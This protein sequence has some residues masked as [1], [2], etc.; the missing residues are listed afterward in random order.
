MLS[1]DE[2]AFNRMVEKHTAALRVVDPEFQQ[3]DRVGQ[4][5]VYAVLAHHFNLRPEQVANLPLTPSFYGL[6]KACELIKQGERPAA[7]LITEAPPEGEWSLPMPK[8]VLMKR[9]NLKPRAFDTFAAQHGLI[10]VSRQQFQIRLD[11]MD[12]KTRARIETDDE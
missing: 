11:K 12:P 7:A 8:K 10:E 4:K 3:G 2:A 1:R 6:V 9:L 5:A